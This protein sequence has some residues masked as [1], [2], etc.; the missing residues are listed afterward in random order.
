MSRANAWFCIPRSSILQFYGAPARSSEYDHHVGL[1]GSALLLARQFS[2]QGCLLFYISW[3]SF[4]FYPIFFAGSKVDFIKEYKA[5]DPDATRE[6]INTAWKQQREAEERRQRYE[7]EEKQRE[8]EEK[9]R[10]AGE[11]RQRYEAEEKQRQA[12]ERRYEAEE[13]QREA[14]ERRQQ[15]I[16]EIF[17]NKS[18]TKEEREIALPHCCCTFALSL[19]LSLH[20]SLYR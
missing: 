19:F 5:V 13:K 3:L 20:A 16:Q 9:Q 14:E 15:R 10:E 17:Q 2:F 8:A 1:A 6:E 7:A 11:R 12:E 18:L 4:L